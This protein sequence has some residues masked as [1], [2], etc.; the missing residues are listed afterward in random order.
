MKTWPKSFKWAIY[1]VKR[2]G[3]L[4]AIRSRLQTGSPQARSGPQMWLVWFHTHCLKIGKFHIK[5]Q[6][7]SCFRKA[8]DLKIRGPHPGTSAWSDAETGFFKQAMPSS[9]PP[10]L[11]LQIIL[12]Q[13]RT[14]PCYLPDHWH[15]F[16]FEDF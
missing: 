8:K 12:Q 13:A 3:E 2:S 5:F 6:I 1:Q 15:T 4:R 9:V 11:R 10:S 14:L 16:E 7:S